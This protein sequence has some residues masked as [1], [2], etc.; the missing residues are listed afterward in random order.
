MSKLNQISSI[1]TKAFR[2]LNESTLSLENISKYKNKIKDKLTCVFLQVSYR[3]QYSSWHHSILAESTPAH[4]SGD[5]PEELSFL[6]AMKGGRPKQG[7]EGAMI[8]QLWPDSGDRL[9]AQLPPGCL[10]DIR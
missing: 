7:M 8:G 2:K 1:L 9:T 6:Y 4:I 5:A 10:A 3:F